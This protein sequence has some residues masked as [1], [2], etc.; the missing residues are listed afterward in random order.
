MS[1][2][3]KAVFKIAERVVTGS[4]VSAALYREVP[5]GKFVAEAATRISD[6]VEV[7]RRSR[8]SV[9]WDQ[10]AIHEWQRATFGE[11]RSNLSIA[12]RAN[13]EM[14]VLL[15]CLSQDDNDTAAR[16]E[17]ADVV[18]VLCHLV[19]RLGGTMARDVDDKMSVNVK[20]IWTRW[21]DG[22]HVREPL[23]G[24]RPEASARISLTEDSFPRCAK[25]GGTGYTSIP[26]EPT[27]IERCYCEEG[28]RA[29][30]RDS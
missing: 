29:V 4:L 21:G 9:K 28:N 25:C 13:E 5:L 20:R 17:V 7:L 2:F 10:H 19:E 6:E 11:P 1:E 18:I 15:R 23:V 3:E 16:A 30:S 14:A 12:I 22:Q 24:A 26:F 8:R 27:T